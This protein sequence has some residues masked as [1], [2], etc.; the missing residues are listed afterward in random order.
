MSPNCGM[1][2]PG[3]LP[4]SGIYVDVAGGRTAAGRRAAQDA[5]RGDSGAEAGQ[6]SR[7]RGRLSFCGSE[8]CFLCCN[9][10]SEAVVLARCMST[11][12]ELAVAAHDAG[13]QGVMSIIQ[14]D[15]ATAAS[16]ALA[17]H[18]LCAQELLQLVEQLGKSAS[19]AAAQKAAGAAAGGAASSG[20]PS[21]ASAAGGGGDTQ[22]AEQP[23]VV[24]ALGPATSTGES[25]RSS[26]EL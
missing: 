5:G 18:L 10:C 22:P 11:T 19:S 1:L 16:R 26:E 12:C 15:V 7:R 6:G 8:Q 2:N 9:C 13:T 23:E 24:M 21:G 25:S 3:M 17:L 4:D 14:D 20:A